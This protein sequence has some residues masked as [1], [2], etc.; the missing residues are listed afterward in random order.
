VGNGVDKRVVK[1][2]EIPGQFSFSRVGFKK[3]GGSPEKDK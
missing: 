2:K 3:G 1:K